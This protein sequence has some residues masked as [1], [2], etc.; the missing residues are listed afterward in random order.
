MAR[1]SSGYN[2]DSYGKGF[3]VMPEGVHKFVI[4]DAL[5][6]FKPGRDPQWKLYLQPV[7]QQYKLPKDKDYL[8]WCPEDG[9]VEALFDAAGKNPADVDPNKDYHPDMFRG[10][11]IA[12]EVFHKKV[13]GDDGEVRTFANI[14]RLHPVFTRRKN[15]EPAPDMSEQGSAPPSRPARPAPD[16]SFDD[17]GNDDDE[18]PF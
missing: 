14:R 4:M 11:Q 6:D 2:P 18:I 10:K 8:C 7:D 12:A 1:K 15:G 13:E 16:E 17:S 9:V 5:E 3:E